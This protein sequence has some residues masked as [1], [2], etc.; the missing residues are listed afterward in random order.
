MKCGHKN[1]ISLYIVID[2]RYIIYMLL[3]LLENLSCPLVME[4]FIIL[5]LTFEFCN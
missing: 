3:L 4:V 5:I 1:K 2:Y